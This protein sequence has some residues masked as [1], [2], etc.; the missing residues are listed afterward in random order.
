MSRFKIIL[1]ISLIIIIL[2][3]IIYYIICRFSNRLNVSKLVILWWIVGLV[4]IW[5]IIWEITTWSSIKALA[6]DILYCLIVFCFLIFL[7]LAIDHLL[8]NFMNFN[9]AW[10]LGFC[11]LIFGIWT[12]FAFHTKVNEITIETDKIT[13]DAKILF[14]SDIHSTALFPKYFIKKLKNYIGETNPDFV[15]IGWDLMNNGK[16]DEA[17]N[18]AILSWIQIPI[19]AVQW[20]HDYEKGEIVEVSDGYAK[21][22]ILKKKLGTI[23]DAKNLNDLKLKKAND[24]KVA[25]QNLAD[26]QEFAKVIETKTVKVSL[27]AG[28]DK[29][30]MKDTVR[31]AIDWIG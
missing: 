25:A 15:L 4:L 28:C 8:S 10:T 2:S 12:F 31:K 30:N 22:F 21:N 19:F 11:A 23:A 20:N 13:Q 6:T 26:A 18:Y 17:K 9:F 16:D 5:V 29:D 24:E 7:I 27:K 1:W 3:S 14:V